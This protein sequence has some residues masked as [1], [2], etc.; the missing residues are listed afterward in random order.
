MPSAATATELPSS[1]SVSMLHL[2]DGSTRITPAYDVVP[3]THLDSDGKM[4]L[5][6]NRKYGHATITIDDLVAEGE[7]WKVRAPRLIITSVLEAV[8]SFASSENPVEQA[9]AGLQDDIARFAK[10]LLSGL[11]EGRIVGA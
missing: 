10:N 8:E 9:Y 7:A 2:P 6:I 11:P 3:Q 1:S 4:A 5:T